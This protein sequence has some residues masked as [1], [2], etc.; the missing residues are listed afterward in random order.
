MGNINIYAS[1]I[2]G[3]ITAM[4]V[5]LSPWL[6]WPR[7]V[8][9]GIAAVLVMVSVYLLLKKPPKVSLGDHFGRATALFVAAATLW[10]GKSLTRVPD[11]VLNLFRKEVGNQIVIIATILLVVAGVGLTVL[12]A[13]KYWRKED[14]RKELVDING[15]G[16]WAVSLLVG[17]VLIIRYT[18]YSIHRLTSAPQVAQVLEAPKFPGVALA[19]IVLFLR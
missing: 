17:A 18:D 7:W 3:L 1:F 2:V 6:D 14:A 13:V 19:R 5:F 9:A 8:P 15:A 4:V 16:V 11:A 10:V 12:G